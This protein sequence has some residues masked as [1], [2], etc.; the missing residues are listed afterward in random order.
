MRP[1]LLSVFLGVRKS[2]C[3]H[4][5]MNVCVYVD[6]NTNMEL[7]VVF[8]LAEQLCLPCSSCSHITL[9]AARVGGDYA[10]TALGSVL[11]ACQAEEQLFNITSV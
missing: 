3:V 2:I 10:I 5:Y 9:C 7:N 1:E 8:T 11:R 4:A 6:L